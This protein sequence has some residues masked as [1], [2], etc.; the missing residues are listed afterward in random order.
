MLR[1]IKKAVLQIGVYT[2]GGERGRKRIA[3][4]I[5]KEGAKEKKERKRERRRRFQS[6]V[7]T[8]RSLLRT[9]R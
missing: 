8:W 7:R 1:T 6:C 9:Q 4:E 2:D 3:K 5:S